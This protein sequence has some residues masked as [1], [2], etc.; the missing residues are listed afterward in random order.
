MDGSQKCCKIKDIFSLRLT[1]GIFPD[2]FKEKGDVG[3]GMGGYN[4]GRGGYRY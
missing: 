3:N 4:A 2:N 1:Q